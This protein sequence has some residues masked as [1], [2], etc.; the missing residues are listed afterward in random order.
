[1]CMAYIISCANLMQWQVS[2]HVPTVGHILCNTMSYHMETHVRA[3]NVKLQV[4]VMLCAHHENK[5]HV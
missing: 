2:Y 1:M 4:I 5:C 3:N